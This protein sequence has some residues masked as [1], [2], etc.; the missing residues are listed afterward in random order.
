[1]PVFSFRT[2]CTSSPVAV[3]VVICPFPLL[4]PVGEIWSSVAGR[5]VEGSPVGSL[6]LSVVSFPVV[7]DVSVEE[8]SVNGKIDVSFC[9]VVAVGTSEVGLPLEIPARVVGSV[10][11]SFD[12]VVAAVVLVLF[13]V[14]VVA[15]V[16]VVLFDVVAAAVVFVVL[17]DVVVPV[18]VVV[19]FD[20]LV[21]AVVVV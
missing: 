1:M 14:I 15:A 9:F 17:C 16:V 12:V 21:A 20:I 7:Q 18:V 13:D 4:G 6:G 10:F 5:V 11:V 19:L 8:E 2:L 3:A